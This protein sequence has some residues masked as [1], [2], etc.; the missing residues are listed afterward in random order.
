MN[1]AMDHRT[2]DISS[3]TSQ[4]DSQVSQ[5]VKESR[6]KMASVLILTLFNLT[7]Y[8]DRFG[9]AGTY[10]KNSLHYQFVSKSLA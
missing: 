2:T 5:D 10:S 7:Y 1:T 8:M 4:S 9:I 3:D 6:L